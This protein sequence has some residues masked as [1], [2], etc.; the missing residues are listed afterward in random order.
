[1]RLVSL[2]LFLALATSSLIAQGSLPATSL[3]GAFHAA[4]IGARAGLGSCGNA[5]VSRGT[6]QFST[7]GS[8]SFT[9][10]G[11]NSDVDSSGSISSAIQFGGSY[12]IGGDGAIQMVQAGNAFPLVGN[13]GVDGDIAVFMR[14]NSTPFDQEA[15]QI[16]MFKESTAASNATLNG[17]YTIRWLRIT[18]NSLRGILATNGGSTYTVNGSGSGSSAGT[19]GS[20][21][22]YTV[23][24]NG[25]LNMQVGATLTGAG[26]ITADGDMFYFVNT[27][28]SSVSLYVG[29]KQTTAQVASQL[30]GEWVFTAQGHAN[31]YDP[32]YVPPGGTTPTGTYGSRTSTTLAATTLVA[33]G[34]ALTHAMDVATLDTFSLIAPPPLYPSCPGGNYSIP[35]ASFSLSGPGAVSGSGSLSLHD[36]SST[37]FTGQVNQSGDFFVGSLPGE[38][39]LCLGV[40][41]PQPSNAFGVSTAGLCPIGP[42][43]RSVSFPRLGNAAFGFVVSQSP[44]GSLSIVGVALGQ[45]PGLPFSGGLIWVDPNTILFTQWL[46]LGGP[47]SSPCDGWVLMPLPIPVDPVFEGLMLYNQAIVLDAAAPGGLAMSAGLEVPIQR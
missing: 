39:T 36:A 20:S 9:F 31:D 24:A 16:L 35:A 13:L 42:W 4:S 43:L 11:T 28:S 15:Y 44:A 10:S 29:V 12:Q 14:P 47:S 30:R 8:G 5:N 7:S 34:G 6:F 33:S 2:P 23:A 26:A 3:Q 19:P 22:S 18:H 37:I 45:A 21:I 40:R 41:I 25:S 46:I 27:T 38:I 32:N 1:M 17:V